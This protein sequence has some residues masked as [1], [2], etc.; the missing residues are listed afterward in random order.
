MA[1]S[2]IPGFHQLSPGERGR[3]VRRRARLTPA[4]SRALIGGI[5]LEGADRMV[6]NVVGVYG[7]PLGVATNFR[8]NGRDRLVPMAIEEPSVVAAASHGAKL[9]RT[10]GGFRARTSKPEMVGQVQLVGAPARAAAAVRARRRALLRVG[11]GSIPSIVAH[12]GGVREVETRW[13]RTRRGRHLVVHFVVDVREAMGANAVNA[14]CEA[15]APLLEEVTG[16]RAVLRIL[17]NLCDRRTVRARAV[18][19][20][21]ELGRDLVR[22]I[23]D[24]GA[25]AEADPYRAATHNKGVLNA[26]AAVA[27]ATGNDTRA[28]EA[29][30]HA[31]AARTG[32]YSSLTAW[33][34]DRRGDLV[35]ELETALAVSTVGGPIQAHPGARA[36]LKLLGARGSADLAGVMA[37]AGLACNFAAMR[38]IVSEGI[39]RGHME[40]HARSVA[41]AAGARGR[42]VEEVA[43]RMAAAGDYT[44][45]R[46]R[47]LLRKFR[48]A[49]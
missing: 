15:T 41:A 12:G 13:V 30:A 8:I 43:A 1:S 26:M 20:A 38:A 25:L 39:R 29:G 36:C 11:N 5:D 24:A 40:L 10:R 45:E 42:E 4:E 46:A 7:V 47:G 27:L 33:R 23:L 16:G 22:G 48:A 35:G 3:V 18:F 6:E 9:A 44:A 32:R 2:R 34:L 49:A 19:P 17:T 14:V 37:S 28:L 21:K 31:Y